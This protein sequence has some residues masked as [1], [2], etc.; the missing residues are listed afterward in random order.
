[1]KLQIYDL[2]LFIGKGYFNNDGAQLYLIFQPIYKTITTFSG[3][4]YSVSEWES[5]GLSNEIFT[6]P[7]TANKS[8]FPKLI[9]NESRIRFKGSC[10][11]QEDKTPFTPKNVVNIFI[12]YELNTWSRDLNTD[13]TLK[14]CLFGAVKLT[15]NADPDKSN[16]VA[17]A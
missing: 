9:W 6:P 3:L 13:F 15:K 14:D 12:V 10:L 17:T 1:M 7:Y 2:N 5:K 4:T 11:K 16:V 8:L